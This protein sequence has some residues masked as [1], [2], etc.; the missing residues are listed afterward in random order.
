M[1]PR[2][3]CSLIMFAPFVPTMTGII[4]SW[5]DTSAYLSA[6]EVTKEDSRDFAAAT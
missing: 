2:T 5:T 6:A 4:H 3:S 1:A